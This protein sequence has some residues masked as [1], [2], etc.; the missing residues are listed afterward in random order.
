MNNANGVEEVGGSFSDITAFPSEDM[1]FQPH[2]F[3]FQDEWV[4]EVRGA[5]DGDSLH[6]LHPF[7]LQA[8][9]SGISMVASSETCS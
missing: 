9:N 3:C 1:R 2:F 4:L 6:M 8:P 7:L 5:D